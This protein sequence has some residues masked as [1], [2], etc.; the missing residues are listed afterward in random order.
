MTPSQAG[1]AGPKAD[2][3]RDKWLKD[4]SKMSAGN[5]SIWMAA[6]VTPGDKDAT[7]KLSS[8][9]DSNIA[10]YLS[11]PL[12][13]EAGGQGTQGNPIIIQ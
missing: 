11:Q 7:K 9:Y 4:N 2:A 13:P 12:A 1:G 8:F 3:A 6:G 5:A 10:P